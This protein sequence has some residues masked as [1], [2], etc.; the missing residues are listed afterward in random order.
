LV[1]ALAWKM[2]PAAP[3]NLI[4]RVPSK[5]HVPAPGCLRPLVPN[6]QTLDGLSAVTPVKRVPAFQLPRGA[7]RQRVPFQ[8][9][10]EPPRKVTAQ[11]SLRDGALA[12][13]IQLCGPAGIGTAL[14]IPF[15]IRSA[16]GVP[17]PPMLL[18]PRNQVWPGQ[19][20]TTSYWLWLVAGGR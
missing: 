6:T 11:M 8:C 9:S 19:A 14:G 7:T 10:T 20:S 5:C 13:V 3:V 2:P 1:A 16:F 18:P 12:A 15:L 4:H 17:W